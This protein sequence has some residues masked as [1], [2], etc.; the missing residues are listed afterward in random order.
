M[1]ADGDTAAIKNAMAALDQATQEFAMR[2]MDAGVRQALTGH[3]PEE[4]SGKL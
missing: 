2:R 1:R 3:R 4:F